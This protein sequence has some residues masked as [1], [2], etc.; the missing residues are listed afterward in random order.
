MRPMKALALLPFAL[1]AACD[2]PTPPAPSPAPTTAVASTAAS[3]SATAAP[4]PSVSVSASA[5]TSASAPSAAIGP[6]P[7]LIDA[8]G[9]PL[10][11]TEEKPS[12]RS[13]SWEQRVKLLFRAIQVD[14]PKI[15]APAFFPLIAYREVK[16][17]ANAEA[18]WNNR[19]MKAYARDIHKAHEQLGKGAMDAQLVGLEVPEDK[20][21][22]MKPGS[23]GNKLGY[24]R[25]LKN[26]LRYL[27][28]AGN[29]HAI[30]ITSL[31]S[32]RGE[33]YVVHVTGFK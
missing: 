29:P 27:D 23:E 31:I 11:Q 33:W 8:A 5:S 25:V 24:F 21:Q 6:V 16:N 19:L 28:A 9:K 10:P 2:K 4:S 18:D 13:L 30:D 1:V 20:A 26:K 15:A 7:V 32:W 22:W 3:S 14:D 17:V 12:L